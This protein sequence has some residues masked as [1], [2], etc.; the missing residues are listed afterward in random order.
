MCNKLNENAWNYLAKYL[1]VHAS[2][3]NNDAYNRRVTRWN[4][5]AGKAPVMVRMQ[6]A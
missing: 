4:R 3:R 5:I 6:R 1:H 2:P